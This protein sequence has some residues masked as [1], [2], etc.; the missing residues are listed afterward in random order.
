MLNK[1]RINCCSYNTSSCVPLRGVFP[2]ASARLLLLPAEPW[3]YKSLCL[4][5][6][7]LSGGAHLLLGGDLPIHLQEVLI[8]DKFVSRL[9]QHQFQDS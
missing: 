9:I 3:R 2:L 1:L 6:W 7:L 8:F 4:L 5:W